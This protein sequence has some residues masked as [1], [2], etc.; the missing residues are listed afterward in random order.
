MFTRSRLIPALVVSCGV[1]AGCAGTPSPPAPAASATPTAPSAP[2]NAWTW[3][4]P[5]PAPE[6]SSEPAPDP[7]ASAPERSVL[8]CTSDGVLA[9]GQVPGEMIY[10][11]EG[12]EQPVSLD[13]LRENGWR[14]EQMGIGAVTQDDGATGLPLSITVRKLR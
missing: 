1:L 9:A 8:T 12:L 5:R 7:L 14:L 11:C 4:A 6:A 2:D 3:T 10:R 13:E